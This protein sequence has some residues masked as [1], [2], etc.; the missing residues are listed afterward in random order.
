MGE[1]HKRLRPY[2]PPSI[3]NISALSYGA[4]GKNAI[5]ALNLGAEKAGCFH[6]TGEGGI[7]DFH[8]LGADIVWQLGTGYFGAR[9]EQGKFSF[10][11]VRSQVALASR[12]RN[13]V[14]ARRQTG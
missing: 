8:R 11:V 6:N 4:L 9:D 1:Y 13:K 14:I 5:S 10:D 2:R 7:S 3:V 12:H